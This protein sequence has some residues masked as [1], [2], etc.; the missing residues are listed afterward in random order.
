MRDRACTY[1]KQLV[2]EIRAYGKY[3]FWNDEEKQ[4]RYSREYQRKVYK[5]YTEAKASK[6]MPKPLQ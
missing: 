5:K 2:D 6:N 4:K 3:A 1:L